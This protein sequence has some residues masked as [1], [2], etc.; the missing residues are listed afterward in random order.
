MQLGRDL[1]PGSRFGKWMVW[2]TTLSQFYKN[3]RRN[4]AT[5]TRVNNGSSFIA[6]PRATALRTVIGVDSLEASG[7]T[8]RIVQWKFL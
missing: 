2:Y 7:N 4:G 8:S 6:D 3:G 5:P 1:V